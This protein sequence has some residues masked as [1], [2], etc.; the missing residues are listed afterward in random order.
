[1]SGRAKDWRAA[2][3]GAGGEVRLDESM[4]RHTTWRVGG[5]V[6]LFYAPASCAA[7]ADFLARLDP[8]VP[9]LWS[10]L[11]SNLLVRDGG[12]RGVVVSLHKGL[13]KVARDGADGVC[14]EAGAPCNRVARRAAAFGLRGAEFLCGIPGT[15]GGALAMNAGAFGGETWNLVSAVRTMDRGG[16]IRRR[17]AAEFEAGYRELR[18]PAGPAGP[19]ADG[20][21]WFIGARLRLRRGDGGESTAQMAE[22]L[23]RRNATQP[24]QSA[25]AGSVFRNPAGD[26][27]ARLID[28]AGLKGRAVGGAAVSSRHANF[29]VNTGAATAADVESLMNQVRAAVFAAHGVQLA[30]EVRIVGEAR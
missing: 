7:L 26:F 15:V 20:G 27:A 16:G 1:M 29:I 14:A 25:S 6:D 22:I 24:A 10:G 23:A 13:T 30:P 18:G 17:D 4:A 11:G 21:E 2:V 8:A 9:V 28:S 19:A 12:L 3:M 5:A